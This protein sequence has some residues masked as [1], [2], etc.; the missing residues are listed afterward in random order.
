MNN[1]SIDNF[2]FLVFLILSLICLLSWRLTF[3]FRKQI[4][5]LRSSSQSQSTKYGQIT[6][7]FMPWASKYPY[8]PSKF[9]FIGSPIDGIQFEEDKVV[10][11]EFKTSSSRM[12]GSQRKI[13]TLVAEGKVTFEE[14]RLA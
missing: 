10:L 1:G 5:E 7:Q 14:I 12:T 6:E 2:V 11:L 4:T 13:K 9:R 3:K 8:D